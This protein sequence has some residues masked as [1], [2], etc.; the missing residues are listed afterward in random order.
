MGCGRGEVC[1]HAAAR[2]ASAI[3]LDPSRAALELAAEATRAWKDL[4]FF[5]EGAH[6]GPW[7]VLGCGRALPFRPGKIDKI[8]LA[9]VLEHLERSEQEETLRECARALRPGGTIA[10]HTQPNRTLVRWT[11]PVLGRLSPLWGVRLPR[12][13]RSEASPGAGLAYHRG[14]LSRSRLERLL[15]RAGLEPREVW[16]EGTWAIHRIFGDLRLKGPLI[17]VFRRSE[18]LRRLFATQVFAAAT[19]GPRA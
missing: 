10:V 13:P 15:R 12:D 17:R 14:E 4:G 7:R 1:L 19:K 2:G 8:V 18:V 6:R 11:F 5:P 16:L 9:D 3:A